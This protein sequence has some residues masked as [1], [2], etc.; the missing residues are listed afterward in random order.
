MN[1]REGN[2]STPEDHRKEWNVPRMSTASSIS[3]ELNSCSLG[4]RSACGVDSYARSSPKDW[5]TTACSAPRNYHLCEPST[6]NCREATP[7]APE[8]LDAREIRVETAWLQEW[9]GQAPASSTLNTLPLC[10]SSFHA[11]LDAHAE[12]NRP[13]AAPQ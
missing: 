4:N 3:P 7:I 1:A 11:G 5:A 6:G 9:R 12:G 10:S 13:L 8:R 2:R